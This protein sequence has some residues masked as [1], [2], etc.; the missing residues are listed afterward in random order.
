MVMVGLLT[1][2]LVTA[3]GPSFSKLTSLY[4]FNMGPLLVQRRTSRTIC[5]V[6]IVDRAILGMDVEFYRRIVERARRKS[7]HIR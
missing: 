5:S 4:A 3:H 7:Y 1:T 2:P 6:D